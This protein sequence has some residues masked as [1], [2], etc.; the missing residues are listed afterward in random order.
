M[1]DMLECIAAAVATNDLTKAEGDQASTRYK[2]LLQGYLDQGKSEPEA[3]AMASAALKEATS[4]EAQTNFH[5]TLA[6]ITRL[7]TNADLIKAAK[8]PG[9][10]A[11]FVTSFF[12]YAEGKGS[13]GKSFQSLHEAWLE[14]FRFHLTDVMDQLHTK[15][16]GA[17]RNIALMENLVRESFG[18]HTGDAMAKKLAEAVTGT[19]D[20]AIRAKNALG[21]DIQI[22][23]NRGMSQTHDA[24]RIA[25]EGFAE[26]RDV[27]E[28]Q[29]DWSRLTDRATGQS[30]SPTP[31][32][33]PPQSVTQRFLRDVYDGITTNGW[34]TTEPAMTMGGQAL[35]ARGAEHRVLHFKNA[36]AQL[37]YNR[38]FGTADPY[39][40]I[41]HAFHGHA[42][43]IALMDIFGPN[44]RL[45]LEWILQNGMKQVTDLNMAA[46]AAAEATG[47]AE[48]IAAAATTAQKSEASLRKAASFA[49]TMMMHAD[50]SVNIVESQALA[51]WMSGVRNTARSAHLGSSVFGAL[52]GDAVT[53]ASAAHMIHIN[54]L[55]VMSQTVKQMSSEMAREDAK[56][57]GYTLEGLMD[58]GAGA[59]SYMGRS[60]T[61][62]LPARLS[63]FTLRASGLNILTDTRK[64]SFALAM[65]DDMASQASQSFDQ[66]GQGLR[67]RFEMRGVTPEM[68]DRLRDPAYGFTRSDGTTSI[69]PH[70]WL[71]KRA[72]AGFPGSNGARDQELAM[73]VAMMGRE[74]VEFA[75]PT[76]SLKAQAYIVGRDPAG[77]AGAELKKSVFGYRSYTASIMLNQYYRFQAARLYGRSPW[78]QLAMLGAGLTLMGGLKI[79]A[80]QIAK[81]EDPRDMT[82]PAFWGAALLQ[83][84]GLGIF[85][86]LISSAT[87]RTGGG[88]SDLIAGP[89]IGLVGDLITPVVNEVKNLIN[90]QPTHVM[91][92]IGRL[93]KNDTPVLTSLW[94]VR[95][96]YSRLVVD[97]LV[98]FLDPAAYQDMQDSADRFRKASGTDT[99]IPRVGSGESLRAPNLGNALGQ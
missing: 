66:L 51:T 5:K 61:T 90:G 36:D 78:A 25:K 84:G 22:L 73:R 16:T 43:D 7:Q 32:M 29:L 21:S 2:E 50:Q 27:I 95:A 81:G 58:G 60:F 8:T 64:V 99:F 59:A 17:P 87:A 33:I 41:M 23:K 38:A 11:H 89:S 13:T 34:D 70:Y 92:D 55:N 98:A 74:Q 71:Q 85:G 20:I 62:G 30:F 4:K 52:G 15:V 79:Q 6:Q 37:A 49:R 76:H 42:R 68:W 14:K 3:K 93:L 47:K 88:I 94:Y 97:E 35:Y 12:Q 77:T 86:D 9:E 82:D 56:R 80:S 24:L 40:G 65:A 18:E 48:T 67:A 26:W 19:E 46:R 10:V 31:D 44:H 57:L 75:V 69:S 54:P 53:M 63:N 28:K 72:E 45:G 96:A 39:S 83:G 91:K 1:S